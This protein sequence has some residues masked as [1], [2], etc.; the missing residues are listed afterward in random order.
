MVD[1]L[2]V[3]SLFLS[4]CYVCVVLLFLNSRDIR[5]QVCTCYI[6][7]CRSINTMRLEQYG[8]HLADDSAFSC[9][10]QGKTTCLLSIKK[11]LA[12]AKASKLTTTNS[13]IPWTPMKTG[14]VAGVANALPLWSTTI[15]CAAVTEVVTKYHF[16]NFSILQECILGSSNHFHIWR[17][18][19]QLS[20]GDTCQIRTWHWKGGYCFGSGDDKRTEEMNLI[21]C[22][23]GWKSTRL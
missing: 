6:Y 11:S 10:Q 22:P 8:G 12:C 17:V 19:P 7:M 16:V 20:C 13:Y 4:V 23:V 1:T 15:L 21:T 9:I 18:S 2:T 14:V 3:T 5:C